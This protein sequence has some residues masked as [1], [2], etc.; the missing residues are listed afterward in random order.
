MTVW[1]IVDLALSGIGVPYA[2]NSMVLPT[3]TDLPDVFIV[4]QMISS[5]PVLHADNLETMRYYRIQVSVYSRNG[6]SNLPNVTARMVSTG[7]TRGPITELP[8]NGDTGHFGL[9]FEF[10]YTTDSEEE[11]ESF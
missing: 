11:S 3:G 1:E 10:V 2:A 7:F 6:L 4:Y 5:P 9:A 8:Y